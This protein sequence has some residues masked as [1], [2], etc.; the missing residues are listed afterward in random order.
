MGLA[1]Q[2]DRARA[3]APLRLRHWE[4][5]ASAILAAVDEGQDSILIHAGIDAQME[6]DL[7]G[8]LVRDVMAALRV[9]LAT[10][11]LRFEDAADGRRTAL[12]VLL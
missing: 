10:E 2:I 1:D 6:A 9:Q 4:A 5:I 11:G 3:M 7:S 12:R 8:V